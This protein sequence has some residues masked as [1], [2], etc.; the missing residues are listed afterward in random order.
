MLAIVEQRPEPAVQD[1]RLG[2]ARQRLLMRVVKLVCESGEYP[3]IMLDVSETGTKL[4]LFNGHPPDAFGMVELSNGEVYPVQR[5]W[6]KD[7][8]AGFRFS[9]PVDT[10]DFINETHSL[11]RRPVRLRIQHS[12]EYVA[13]GERG[14]GVMVDIS[15]RGACIE[16]GRILPIGSALKVEIGGRAGR[17]AHVCW[18]KDY[19]HGLAFQEELSL[20][21]LSQLATELQPFQP[22][23]TSVVVSPDLARPLSA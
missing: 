16:A 20:A 2:A 19:R 15:A 4:K 11:G 18:R 7:N 17:F 9:G 3:C 5:R 6:A 1:R 12:I 23:G 13:A 14:H 21:E 8:I 10:A 22:L